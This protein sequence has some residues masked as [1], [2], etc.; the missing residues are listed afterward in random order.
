MLRRHGQGVTDSV[1]VV[2]SECGLEVNRQ[3]SGKFVGGG[4]QLAMAVDTKLDNS[5]NTGSA[6]VSHTTSVEETSHCCA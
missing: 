4:K 1:I 2:D 3:F 6:M 5:L